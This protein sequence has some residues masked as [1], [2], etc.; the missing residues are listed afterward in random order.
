MSI[1][2]FQIRN[3]HPLFVEMEKHGNGFKARVFKNGEKGCVYFN[4]KTE[5]D[6]ERKAFNY[7]RNKGK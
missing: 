1:I 7:I 5:G 4:A 6:L 3:S 2:A